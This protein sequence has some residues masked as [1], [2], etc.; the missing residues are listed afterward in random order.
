[1]GCCVRDVGQA[2]LDQPRHAQ[3]AGEGLASGDWK[4]GDEP[5]AFCGALTVLEHYSDR[6]SGKAHATAR[7]CPRCGELAF[8][9]DRPGPV[10]VSVGPTIQSGRY[11]R[12]RFALLPGGVTTYED[13]WLIWHLFDAGVKQDKAREQVQYVVGAEIERGFEEVFTPDIHELSVVAVKDMSLS[14]SFRSWP[15][16]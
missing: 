6:I 10:Q 1:M 14:A 5:C 16:V 3:F 13:G 8:W 15:A 4:D 9:P 11:N 7:N 2:L 12:I